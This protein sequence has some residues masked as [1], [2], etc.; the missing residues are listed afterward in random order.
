MDYYDLLLANKLSGGGGGGGGNAVQ[1][2]Q[3]TPANILNMFYALEQGTAH[4]GTFTLAQTLPNTEVTLFDTGFGDNL[5]GFAIFDTNFDYSSIN[6][7]SNARQLILIAKSI[8]P[9]GKRSD[10]TYAGFGISVQNTPNSVQNFCGAAYFTG[11]DD[12]F[13]SARWSIRNGVIY[14][15]G[16][17]NNNWQYTPLRANTELLWIAWGVAQ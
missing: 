9:Y 17:Y 2:G 5:D 4:T 10:Y 1:I 3:S 16:D 7:G 11:E 8:V 15:K 14:A 13:Q 12:A 6:S